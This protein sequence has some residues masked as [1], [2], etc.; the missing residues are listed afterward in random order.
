MSF[1]WIGEILR[2][3][4]SGSRISTADTK[5]Y[6]K[7]VGTA[8]K[9]TNNLT[10]SVDDFGLAAKQTSEGAIDSLT[11]TSGLGAAFTSVAGRIKSSIT[12]LSAFSKAL[13][14][15]G[16]GAAGV[17]SYRWGSYGAR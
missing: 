8:E 15:T 16:I 14:A 4:L 7:A 3:D 10:G 2:I 13:I 1:G 6:T 11:G 12:Q 17:C 5:Q 9:A